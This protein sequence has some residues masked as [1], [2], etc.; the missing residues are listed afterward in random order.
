MQMA[1]ISSALYNYQINQKLSYVSILTSPTTGGVIAAKT[2]KI[3]FPQIF[4]LIFRIFS[5][6]C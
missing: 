6:L 3:I 4:N 2:I 1:K 5:L